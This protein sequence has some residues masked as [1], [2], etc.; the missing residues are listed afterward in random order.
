MKLYA[1]TSYHNATFG[2][3]YPMFRYISEDKAKCEAVLAEKLENQLHKASYTI[4]EFETD[5]NLNY[6]ISHIEY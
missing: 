5:A 4:V 1:V 3:V 2:I 6:L